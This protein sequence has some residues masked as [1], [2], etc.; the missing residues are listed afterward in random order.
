MA[1]P[2]PLKLFNPERLGRVVIVGV[3][4]TGSYVVSQLCRL[5]YGL[6]ERGRDIPTVLLVDGDEV[7]PQN[8]V[9]QYYLPADLRRNKAVVLAERYARAY[10]IAVEALPQYLDADTDL[11][12]IA[13][14]R[15]YYNNFSYSVFVGCVD[16]GTAR[17][18]L[19]D[20]LQADYQNVVYIDAGNEAVSL[21]EDPE[22]VDRY[23]LARF[24]D[25]GWSG[26]VVAG[27]RANNVN[28]LPFPGE[29]FPNLIED[30]EPVL[31]EEACGNV[32]TTEP[33]RHLTNHFAAVAVMGYLNSLLSEGTLVNSRTF[34]DARSGYMRSDTA[35]S[36]LLELGIPG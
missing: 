26:Q 16:N 22:H 36:A 4:G 17:R 31:R 18:V 33:Q 12:Q 30:D 21:P 32:T 7:E 8:L 2:T 14:R 10:G 6:K 5:L 3:G 34:F 20:R 29:V 24:R 27:V 9:R 19:H 25:S 1:Q 13:G 11:A 28:H 15:P 23:G 35:S